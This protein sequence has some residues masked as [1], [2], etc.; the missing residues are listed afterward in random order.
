[1]NRIKRNPLV[2]Y[3][4]VDGETVLYH[5]DSA[6]TF[7]LNPTGALVW[8]ACD[9]SVIEVIVECLQ[10]VYPKEDRERLAADVGNFI[11]SLE[12]AGLLEVSNDTLDA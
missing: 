11:F 4:E 10:A 8:R 7:Q 3:D 6:E 12:E 2:I 1:M 5:T 9:D